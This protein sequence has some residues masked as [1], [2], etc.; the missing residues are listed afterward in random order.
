MNNEILELLRSTQTI[1][2]FTIVLL[3]LMIS[4]LGLYIRE[5]A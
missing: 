2:S 1:F 4:G 3:I 5:I